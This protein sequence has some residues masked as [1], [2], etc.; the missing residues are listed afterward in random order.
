MSQISPAYSRQLPT[1][2]PFSLIPAPDGGYLALKKGEVPEDKKNKSW[3]EY[4]K[5]ISFLK[6]DK[7]YKLISEVSLSASSGICSGHYYE[8]RKIGSKFWFIYLEPGPGYDIGNIKAVEVDPLTLSQKN[9]KT[10]IA[11]TTI[12]QTIT[13]NHIWDLH[14]MSGASPKGSF[15][16]IYIQVSEDQFFLACFDENFNSRWGRKE[17]M[18]DGLK[19]GGTCAMAIDDAGYLYMGEQHKKGGLFFSIYSP[20]G[21]SD[22]HEVNLA[23]GNAREIL[24]HPM[25]INDQVFVSGTYMESDFCTGV[26]KALVSKKGELNNIVTTVFPKQIIESMDTEGF[27]STK[28]KKYGLQPA[29][30]AK[31]V[32]KTDGGIGMIIEPYKVVGAGTIFQMVTGSVIYVNLATPKPVFARAP[33]YTVCARINDY[34][35]NANYVNGGLY[36]A[37]PND[38]KMIIFYFDNPENLSR[39]LALDAKVVNPNNPVVVAAV[40][41]KD[42]NIKRQ[43]VTTTTLSSLDLTGMQAPA[44]AILVPIG[45]GIRKSQASELIAIVKL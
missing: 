32:E 10:I 44:G 40:I 4:K 42:G 7:D 34:D 23:T 43:M 8:L 17:K 27:G 28:A 11:A 14:F 12:D 16:Y 38:S 45:Y 21:Q 13:R 1:F 41:D 30:I 5:A 3:N 31:P 39:D 22:R 9:V 26:Y 2:F 19:K 35:F 37:C 29:F 25:E 18:M 24:F 15:S 36:Y 20:S 33:K 6:Y